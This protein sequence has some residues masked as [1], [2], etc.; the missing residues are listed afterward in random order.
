MVDLRSAQ[1]R[2]R[3]LSMEIRERQYAEGM[4]VIQASD[5]ATDIYNLILNECPHLPEEEV[6]R[7]FRKRQA[8]E[9]EAVLGEAL[10]REYNL[11]HK[12]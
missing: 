1:E 8:A 6:V 4:R 7:L 11:S 3:S 2:A 12:R 5:W 10:F 9:A